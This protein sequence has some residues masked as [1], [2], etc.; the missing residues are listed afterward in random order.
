MN[1]SYPLKDGE[2]FKV[3]FQVSAEEMQ[4]IESNPRNFQK[5]LG[6]QILGMLRQGE[7]AGF[8]SMETNRDGAVTNQQGGKYPI[9]VFRLE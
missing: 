9:S 3:Q 7:S 5:Q 8:R 1:A 2:T 4:A 6:E